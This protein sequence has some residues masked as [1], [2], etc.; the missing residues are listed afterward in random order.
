MVLGRVPET[1]IKDQQLD[2]S[3]QEGVSQVQDHRESQDFTEP[4]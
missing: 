3:G 2:E 1:K 4:E